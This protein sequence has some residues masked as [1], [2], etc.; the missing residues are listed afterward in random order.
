MLLVGCYVS[1]PSDI[2]IIY[3]ESKSESRIC[4]IFFMSTGIY[5]NKVP[6]YLFS[7]QALRGGTACNQNFL[8]EERSHFSPFFIKGV[9]NPLKYENSSEI[10]L[11]LGQIKFL[12]VHRFHSWIYFL[13]FYSWRKVKGRN[14]LFLRNGK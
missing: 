10:S 4:L 2:H 3:I 6:L 8:K 1:I 13:F 7:S 5:Y 12:D 14:T 11:T 9:A